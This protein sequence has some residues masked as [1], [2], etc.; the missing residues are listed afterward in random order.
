MQDASRR[1]WGNFA[2]IAKFSLCFEIFLCSEISLHSEFSL[3]SEI[4]AM[5]A[6]FRYIAKISPVAKLPASCFC[7]QTTPFLVFSISTLIVIILFMIDWYFHLFVR[8]YKPSYEQF[9]T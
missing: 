5:L 2:R 1:S 9:V 6:K 3:Y 8:L 7:V 4:F